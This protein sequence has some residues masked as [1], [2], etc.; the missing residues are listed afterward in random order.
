ME[1]KGKRIVLGVTGGIAAY[2]AAELL[3]LLVKQGAEVQVAMTEGATHFVT[4]TTF[5]ALS[6]KPV[7]TDQWDARMPNAMAH[8]DLSRQADLILIAPASADFMARVAQGMADD[9][10]ATMVLARDCPLLLAPAMNRQMWENPATR[11]NV[12]KL[13]A[14]GVRI[15]G[16]ASGEQACGEIGAGRMLE[17]EEI[18]EEV[19]AFFA[20]KVLAGK[21]MLLTAGPTFEAI[22][23]VRGITNLSSGRMGYA[24]ARAARQAGAIVTLVS[25]PVACAVP[26][27]VEC[28]KVRS[29]LEMHAAVM[30][31]ATEADIFI[32]VAAVADYRVANVA[33]HKLKKDTGGVP[34]IELVENPD[35]LAEVAALPDAPFCVGFA[36]ESRNLEE[37][38]QTKRHKKKIPLIAGN[39]IQE[40]FGGDDNRL[41]LF[42]DTGIHPLA[43]APKSELARQLIEHIANLTGAN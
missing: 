31:R 12:L 1:L 10:L 43:P 32:G 27:G 28:V 5:Q 2:K 11:R 36:A 38:A 14:D 19:A 3:R 33:E 18:L 41:V 23:A 7:F 16:P 24:V 35:I 42:D 22:D 4:P 29:A 34:P 25:G 13:A 37:Y 21:R 40:G 8:I 17:P 6:G 15:I 20:P 39:L 26:Q 9:L 30:A